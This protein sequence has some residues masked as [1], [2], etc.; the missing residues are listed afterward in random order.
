VL[1]SEPAVSPLQESVCKRLKKLSVRDYLVLGHHIL[2]DHF[3]YV[4]ELLSPALLS[5][6]VK[7]TADESFIAHNVCVVCCLAY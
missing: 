7:K 4:A 6:D 3:E 2:R 5:S 1:P